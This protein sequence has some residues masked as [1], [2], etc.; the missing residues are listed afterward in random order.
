MLRIPWRAAI[1]PAS[2]VLS[3][4]KRAD[5]SKRPAACSNTG[6]MARQG[7]HQGAQKSTISGRPFCVTC[8]S[9][10]PAVSVIGCP[11]NSAS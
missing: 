3:L 4:A 10:L 7:A 9:K 11:P 2:S 1:A 8:R 5:G 6:A